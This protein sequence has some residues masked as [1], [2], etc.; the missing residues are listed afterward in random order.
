MSMRKPLRPKFNHYK[1]TI[2]ACYVGYIT[3]A[4]VNNFT[5]LLFLTFS[6]DYGVSISQITMLTMLNFSVQLMV[7][8]LCVKFVDRI[9]YRRCIQAAH[10][11]S[12]IGI[13]GLTIF[14]E[15]CPA[16]YIG[17]M[18]SV[19][20]Y[21]IGGGVIEVL[22][23]PIV[24]ACPTEGKT[25]AM[26][27]LHSFYCWGHLAV[28]LIS[29]AF[30]AAFGIRYWP[31]LAGLWALIP[32]ANTICFSWV[33]LYPVVREGEGLP[34]KTLVRK[35]SFW[36]L[37]ILMICAG[38]SETAMSQ[39]SSAF[40]ESFLQISKTI[41]DIA[42]PGMFALCMGTSRALYGKLSNRIPL[43]PAM[44]ACGMLCAVCYITAAWAT[45]PVLGLFGCA[46]CG[47]SVGVFWP[48]T[49]SLAASI[50]PDG[51]TAMYALLAMAG[52]MGGSIGPTVVGL[53]ASVTDGQLQKGLFVAVA[54]PVIMLLGV[55]QI[56]RGSSR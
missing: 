12:G 32:F 41:G 36:L 4:I 39:W 29:T 15:I 26:S 13:V 56:R 18:I 6:R 43:R 2:R 7:D 21:A 45:V 55:T 52:D 25:A 51:G 23:S 28:V 1:Y 46:V 42:G 31:I 22:I 33:P 40:A 54:F 3:Q 14:P 44:I 49:F 30:F 17:L 20:L 35:R 9:G 47:F 48:G 8:S 24:E 50:I 38:A 11:F 16:P 10:I 34:P 37:T 27:L 5:P 19:V 53:T